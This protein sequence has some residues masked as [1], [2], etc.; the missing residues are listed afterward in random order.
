[1]NVEKAV[2]ILKKSAEQGKN[3]RDV[4]KYLS[5]RSRTKDHTSARTIYLS[6]QK[7]G[8]KAEYEDIY[9]ALKAMSD[10]GVGQPK[11]D[12]QGNVIGLVNIA[13]SL[14]SVG[15]AAISRGELE[16]WKQRKRYMPL[17]EMDA[18]QPQAASSTQPQNMLVPSV[19]VYIGGRPTTIPLPEG[20]SDEAL[21]N[22][23]NRLLSK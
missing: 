16:T 19:T 15:A 23:I 2:T 13:V 17:E 9:K 10:A 7:E 6:M 3:V 1:M 21:G 20:L 5:E 11:F 8:Y 22:F 18:P 4:F 14:Q 12:K